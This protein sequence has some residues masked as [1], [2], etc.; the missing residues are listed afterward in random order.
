INA[1]LTGGK[2]VLINGGCR[3]NQR[4]VAG[5]VSLAAGEYGHDRWKAGASGCTYTFAESAGVTTLTITSGS[6]IQVVEGANLVSDDYTLS[7]VGTAQGK[8]DAGSYGD[9]GLTAAVVGGVNLSVEFGTGTLAQVQ[10]ERKTIATGFEYRSIAEELALCQRYFVYIPEWAIPH[11]T[12]VGEH[13]SIYMSWPVSMRSSPTVSR[14]DSGNGGTIVRTRT[15]ANGWAAQKEST[16]DGPDNTFI[17]QDIY[18][19]AEL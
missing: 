5:T 10:L 1:L 2:N 12:P 3:V 11:V 15:S 19:D 14:T 6:L 7:W 17:V 13:I 18:A 16:Y 8:I 9:S 4:A